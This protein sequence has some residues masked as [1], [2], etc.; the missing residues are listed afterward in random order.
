MHI[1]LLFGFLG[2]GKTTL[3]RRLLTRPVD[4]LKTAVIVNEF[5]DVGVDG[6][7]L[8]GSSVD[9]IELTS[10]CLCCTLR[11]ALS[12][13]LE[14]LR[15]MQQVERVIVEATGVAQPAE[16]LESLAEPGGT[17]EARSRTTR[18]GRGHRKAPE[19]P[20]DAGRVLCESGEA[21]DIVVLNKCDLVTPDDLEK[22]RAQILALNPAADIVFA[23]QGDIDAGHLLQGMTRLWPVRESGAVCQ[24]E[25]HHATDNGIGHDEG[26]AHPPAP[27][28]SFVLRPGGEASRRDLE[29]FFGG[30]TDDVWRAKGYVFLEGGCHLVVRDGTARDHGC[31]RATGAVRYMVFIGRDMDRTAI[32]RRFQFAGATHEATAACT[33]HRL[34]VDG[35]RA[36]RDRSTATARQLSVEAGA[37]RGARRRRRFGRH[38]CPCHRARARQALEPAARRRQSSRRRRH[39]RG[40]GRGV[41]DTGRLYP[42]AD[43]SRP[44][45]QNVILR[46]KP[47]YALGDF[48]PIV[49]V[50]YTPLIIAANPR[51]PAANVKELIAYAKANPGKLKWASAGNG[52]NPHTALEVFKYLT[53]TDILHVAYKGGTA[54]ITGLISGEVDATTRPLRL[55]NRTLPRGASRFLR[56]AET[57]ALPRFPACRRY[58]S[59]ASRRRERTTG[60][61]LVTTTK[62]PQPIVDHINRDVNG[63][64]K[65]TD[66]RNR[67]AHLGIEVEGGTAEAFEKFIKAE[68][69]QLTALVKAGALQPV[70]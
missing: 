50:G 46:H 55:R 48:A 11:G 45:L 21:R 56:S 13:A 35:C 57:N 2:A 34:C 18:D 3:V 15:D 67:F 52:S 53:N 61:G 23:E 17:L 47:P 37:A 19:A 32:E 58:P 40:A 8:S 1:N 25:P 30:L 38:G 31:A 14:E 43:E 49:F 9:V 64:L 39:P 70:D 16:M 36:M 42:A 62:S 10:G 68:A 28:E 33:L 59:R 27:A 24:D 6:Q 7:I 60:T 12:L 69:D 41:G 4:K 5:G 63:I 65:T 29:H 22:A 20:A 66:V 26:H 51:L 54:P 44:G